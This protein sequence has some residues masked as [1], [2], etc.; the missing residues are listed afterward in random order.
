M[1]DGHSCPSRSQHLLLMARSRL[2]VKSCISH[3]LWRGLGH[4]CP[5]YVQ[6]AAGAMYRKPKVRK[7]SEKPLLRIVTPFPLVSSPLKIFLPPCHAT[8]VSADAHCLHPG[9]DACVSGTVWMEPTTVVLVGSRV[10]LR[11]IS[12]LCRSAIQFSRM[13]VARRRSLRRR[14]EA[15]SEVSG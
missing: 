5:S 9:R 7:T 8:V 6:L 10:M 15:K 11:R 14:V 3:A 13:S 2:I 1:Y 12:M 4:E